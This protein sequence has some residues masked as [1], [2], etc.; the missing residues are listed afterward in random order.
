VQPGGI[1]A[2]GG[3]V[4]NCRLVAVNGASTEGM[5]TKQVTEMLRQAAAT[6]ETRVLAFSKPP[7]KVHA[8]QYE[9]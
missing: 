2:A 6:G 4:V 5:T 7:E 1:A 3:V 9:A 8:A